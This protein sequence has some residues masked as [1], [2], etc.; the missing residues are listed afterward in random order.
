MLL[1]FRRV[2][3]RSLLYHADVG[4]AIEEMRGKR[5]A[6]RV[7]RD[8]LGDPGSLCGTSQYGPGAL[9]RQTAAACVEEQSRRPASTSYQIWTAAD[10]VRR[11]RVAGVGPDRHHPL[12][13]A[14]ASQ[15]HRTGVQVDV[16]HVQP[17]R[18]GDART[19]AVE[20]LQQRGVTS[21]QYGGLRLCTRGGN[22]DPRYLIHGKCLR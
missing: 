9:T 3:F 6:E 8:L 20:K 14:L 13:A 12:L 21:R 15:Q 4:A 2:L 5:V 10:L 18:L 17:D 1:E 11:Q 16:V 22:K 7:W 19:R